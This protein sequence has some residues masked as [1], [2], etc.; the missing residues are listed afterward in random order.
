DI[1]AYAG[2]KLLE[3]KDAEWAGVT[4]LA[5]A[6]HVVLTGAVKTDAVKKRVEELVRG[7][8]R[9]RSFR[10][11]LLVGD[12]GSMAKDFALEAE[13]NATLTA[14]KGVASVNMRWCAVGGNVVLMGVAQS[15]EEADLAASKVKGI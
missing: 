12:I 2:K 6:Q 4:T 9:I 5:F 11:E 8:K 14:T 3:A 1:V 7:D 13:V 10:S 15:R